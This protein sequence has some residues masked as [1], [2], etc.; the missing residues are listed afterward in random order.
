[1]GGHPYEAATQLGGMGAVLYAGRRGSA[2][3]RDQLDDIRDE[4]MDL[5]P[6]AV[7]VAGGRT[8]SG[9]KVPEQAVYNPNGRGK[10]FPDLTFDMPDG[11]QVYINTVDT[12][13]DGV[14]AT[15]R[16][17]EAAVDITTWGSG[18]AIMI[19]KEQ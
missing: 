2:K 4:F 1:M 19:P 8:A 5:N 18:P 13:A 11:S 17:L 7:H 6:D 12:Y 3:T 14:T 15:I 16:E 10:R 9:E